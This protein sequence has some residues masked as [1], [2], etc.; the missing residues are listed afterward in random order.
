MVF[1]Q[2]LRENKVLTH[3]EDFSELK[4]M[5]KVFSIEQYVHILSLL[6]IFL[7]LIHFPA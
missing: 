6:R 5:P 3:V 1:Y 7:T 4:E 2:T